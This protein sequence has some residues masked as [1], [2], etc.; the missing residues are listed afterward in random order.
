MT[1]K[2]RRTAFEL[3]G[4]RG[5]RG[6]FPENTLEGFAATIRL[7]VDSLE[8]D[9]AL[10]RDGVAVVF[11]DATLS[12]DIARDASGAWIVRDDIAIHQL[13]RE[14]LSGFDVGRLRPGSDYA[15]RYAGQGVID[16]ARIPDLKAVLLLTAGTGVRL[17]IELKTLP[18]RPGLT[19]SAIDM[20]DHVM[21]LIDHLGAIDRV[22]IRSFDWRSLLHL[23]TTR[24]EVKLTWLTSPRTV[25]EHDLWW[26]PSSPADP[27]AAIVEAAGP[28]ADPCWAPEIAGLTPEMVASAH[29]A[30]L[31][32]V[33]WTVNDAAAIEVLI[34]WGV[35][36]ICTDRPDIARAVMRAGGL[37]V[38]QSGQESV[39]QSG[40]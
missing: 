19:A 33:P 4:H 13:D 30:G 23:R 28:G 21:A 31:R 8:L 25:R 10:T 36:G 16:G 14:Q 40:R 12:P 15:S 39:P 3:Q 1:T 18:D 24:P 22:D 20:A 34:A 27:V 17:D 6:L 26:W 7:G 38:P 11:H 32:V 5:A 29:K 37:P 2:P 9:V 35:D